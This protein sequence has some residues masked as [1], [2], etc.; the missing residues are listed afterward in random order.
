VIEVQDTG[1]GIPV[2]ALPYI[3]DRFYRVDK[4]RG[5]ETGGSALG[6]AIAKSICDL[7]G[8]EIDIDNSIGGGAA[9]RVSIPTA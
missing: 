2:E 3:F 5:R 4:A 6:L 8:G 1:R 7:H 9:V